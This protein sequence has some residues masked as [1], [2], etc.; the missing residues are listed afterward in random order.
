MNFIA[1]DFETA[2]YS[3]TSA[4]SIG[5]VK[6]RNNKKVDDF[7]SLIRPPRLFVRS[8]FTDIHHLTVDDVRDAE[9]FV[10]LW[11]KQIKNFIGDE[12]LVA[13]NASFDMKVLAS[14]LAH[15]DCEVPNLKYFDSLALARRTWRTL[16]RHALTFLGEH[17]GI[18]YDAHNALADAEV[19]AC[20]VLRA[21][22]CALKGKCAPVQTS[23]NADG[24]LEKS[25]DENNFE[26]LKDL[27]VEDLLKELSLP[28][29]NLSDLKL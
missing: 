5:L 29:K 22:Q 10:N 2:N 16:P 26:E 14:T 11:H 4:I 1:I 3:P 20:I 25:F 8:D 18:E 9:K 27:S 24:K 13:H 7:Y 12:I 21:A 19:C 28:L 17:F 6:Y 23:E 15:Y